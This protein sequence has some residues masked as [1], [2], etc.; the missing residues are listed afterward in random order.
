[1]PDPKL[2][3]IRDFSPNHFDPILSPEFDLWAIIDA[4]IPYFYPKFQIRLCKKPVGF[5]LFVFPTHNGHSSSF[6][7][8]DI[9]NFTIYWLKCGWI[10]EIHWRRFH[11]SLHSSAE[12]NQV[13]CLGPNC[14]V[15]FKVQSLNLYNDRCSVPPV[16]FFVLNPLLS[17]SDRLI[18][19]NEICLPPAVV[20]IIRWVLM[21]ACISHFLSTTG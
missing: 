12:L 13:G 15:F 1:M 7:A 4:I 3:K 8:L 14:C 18:A 17:A 5:F 11:S 10:F 16:V 21:V 2:P 20:L 6:I 9:A 19:L